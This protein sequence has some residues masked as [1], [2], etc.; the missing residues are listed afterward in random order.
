TARRVARS[1]APFCREKPR[2]ARA[3]AS[4][5]ARMLRSFK[6]AAGTDPSGVS[7]VN[8]ASSIGEFKVNPLANVIIARERFLPV[9]PVRLRE[10]RR[11]LRLRV[12]LPV[13]LRLQVRG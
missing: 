6:L 5:G 13:R 2:T 7:C 11:V 1:A 12:Q 4:M 10:Q 9:R 8:E 3:C